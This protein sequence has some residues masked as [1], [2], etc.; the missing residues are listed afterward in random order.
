MKPYLYETKSEFLFL[1]RMPRY[2][3]STVVL[4][5]LF[6]ACF[7]ISLA[8]KSGGGFST[9]YLAAYSAWGVMAVSLWGIAATI[10]SERGFG[11]LQVKRASP[12]PPLAY[13][14]AKVASAL[15][16]S[17]LVIICMF[18]MASLWGGVHLAPGNWLLLAIALLFGALPFCALGFLLG[19]ILGPTSA[20]GVVNLI[21]LPM[22]FCSGIWIPLQYLPELVQRF[23]PAIPAYHFAQL[24]FSIV[25]SPVKS[26]P[27]VSIEALFAFALIFGGGAWLAWRREETNVFG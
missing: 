22:M 20:P 24:T 12:M 13:F 10:A 9:M 11:W 7:G 6:Y 4:P 26:T 3:V 15:L 17:T 1:L 21:F 27:M 25:G 19:Y 16:F 18:L 2:S 14:V 5:L 23:A 8:R